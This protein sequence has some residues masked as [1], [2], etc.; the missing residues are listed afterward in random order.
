MRGLTTQREKVIKKGFI[1]YKRYGALSFFKVA[2]RQSTDYLIQRKADPLHIRFPSK[3]LF[4]DL[5]HR[6]ADLRPENF[7]G[8]QIYLLTDQDV[9]SALKSLAISIKSSKEL[10][11][12]EISAGVFYIYYLCDSDA[13]PELERI[14]KYGGIYIPHLRFDKTSYRFINRLALNALLKTESKANRISHFGSIVHEN[15]CEALFMTRD[16]EGDYIEVGVYKGGSALTALYFLDELSASGLSHTKR[17]AWLLDTFDGF[18]Y[19]E[20]D[21]S[22]DVIWAGTHKLLGPEQ[23]IS[24]ITETFS[25][26]KNSY[27]LIKNNICADQ[28]PK[29]IEKIAVANIDVDMYEPTLASLQKISP[30]MAA[31]GVIIC[32][33]AAS[34]PGLY[35]AL[36]AMEEFLKCEEGKSYTKIFKGGQYFLIKDRYETKI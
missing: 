34:T 19:S 10:T 9:S 7:L 5:Q 30:H 11:E 32:E 12:R 26:V 31:G 24:Y 21:K 3:T 20:A 8:K 17:M 33:D 23:T 14:Q 13:I 1:H 16:I 35:G 29:L 22:S 2:F 27:S 36:L 15:I 4:V 25:D 28:L 18:T 6:E